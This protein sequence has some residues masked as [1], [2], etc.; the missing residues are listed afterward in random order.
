MS[1]ARN[2]LPPVTLHVVVGAGEAQL[3]WA[4]GRHGGRFDGTHPAHLLS[5]MARRV[6]SFA[7]G[8]VL[9][10]GGLLGSAYVIL[11]AENFSSRSLAAYCFF[12]VAGAL[13]LWHDFLL[14][15]LRQRS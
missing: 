11:W 8:A 5:A 10:L 14:P 9:F 15:V 1:S 6:L 13:W 7:L 4:G 2:R 3:R 12:V